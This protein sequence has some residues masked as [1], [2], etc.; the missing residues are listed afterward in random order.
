VKVDWPAAPG[1]SGYVHVTMGRIGTPDVQAPAAN[2]APRSSP[3]APATVTSTVP[4]TANIPMYGRTSA[5]EQVVPRGEM[6]AQPRQSTTPPRGQTSGESRS[7][8]HAVPT[9]QLKIATPS[10]VFGLGGV[11]GSRESFGAT[12]RA[13]SNSHLGIQLALTRDVA[14]SAI[15]EGR[16]T[17][18]QIEPGIVYVPFDLVSENL[19]IRPYAGSVVS[20]RSQTLSATVPGLSGAS[21]RNLGFRVFGGTELTFASM[22]RFGLSVDLGYRHYPTPFPGFDV[23]PLNLAIAGHWYI[24]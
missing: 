12:A 3:P 16:L 18:T 17:S 15:A 6:N 13:W 7:Q 1:G 10:H 20:F 22:P 2:V 4:A 9:S 14:T 5:G 21:D 8:T 23:R 11:I 24:K 19:W